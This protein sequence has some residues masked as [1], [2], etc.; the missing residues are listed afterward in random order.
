MKTFVV[1]AGL[2][3]V[4]PH[5]DKNTGEWKSLTVLVLDTAHAGHQLG[6]PVQDHETTVANFG[7]K[8]PAPLSG[9]WTVKSAASG[10]I[11][12]REKGSTYTPGDLHCDGPPPCPGKLPLPREGC[13]G[14]GFETDPGCRIGKRPLVRARLTFTGGWK[15][16]PMEYSH[17]REPQAGVESTTPSGAS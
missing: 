16:R 14:A 10:P 3:L 13:L 7:G 5:E 12:V 15:V 17:N 4:V 2:M 11:Q 8:A 9:N 6:K 1:L